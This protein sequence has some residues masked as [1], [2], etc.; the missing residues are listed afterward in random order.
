MIRKWPDI[1][2]KYAFGQGSTLG[3]VVREFSNFCRLFEFFIMRIFSCVYITKKG[4]TIAHNHF[5]E[6]IASN[7]GSLSISIHKEDIDLKIPKYELFFKEAT[8]INYSIINP[9]CQSTSVI[10]NFKA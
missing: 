2:N 10:I 3:E 6:S 9:L 1:D 8:V 5:A 7:D 4:D